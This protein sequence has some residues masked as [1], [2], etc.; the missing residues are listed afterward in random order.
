MK[1]ISTEKEYE[2]L[3]EEMEA[4]LKNV[5]ALNPHE[6]KKLD[7]ISDAISNYEE[8]HYSMRPETLIE[9]IE[10]RMYQRKLKQKDL[11]ELLD[12]S[13]SR[14]NEFLKGK[15]KLTYEL[16]RKLYGKLNIEAEM[17]FGAR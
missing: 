6:L 17:I 7:E 5:D 9:M 2:I 10:L 8:I 1:T 16:A 12:T 15:R 3:T 11:A 4:L 13:P 14:I